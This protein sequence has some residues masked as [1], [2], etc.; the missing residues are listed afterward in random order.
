MTTTQ[1]FIRFLKD[2]NIY[3]PVMR[4][5][6]TII[7]FH[8]GMFE[9]IT[10]IIPLERILFDSG[11]KNYSTVMSKW[12]KVRFNATV[13]DKNHSFTNWATEIFITF[14][15]EFNIEKEVTEV[16]YSQGNISYKTIKIN[17]ID[18]LLRSNKVNLYEFFMDTHTFCSWIDYQDLLEDKKIEWNDVDN[19]WRKFL[20]FRQIP[21]LYV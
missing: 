2:E 6:K 17:D 21:N 11:V 10:A 19:Q 4:Y 8:D 1:L 18:K 13:E 20:K 9:V 15:K 16:L 3:L 7:L 12:Y 14:I 5:L